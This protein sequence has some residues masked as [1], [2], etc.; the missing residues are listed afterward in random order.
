MAVKGRFK[1][2]DRHYLEGTQFD[3]ALITVSE[4]VD[5]K[6]GEAK[7]SER[8]HYFPKLTQV[9]SYLVAEEARVA[10]TAKELVDAISR[11]TQEITERLMGVEERLSREGNTAKIESVTEGEGNGNDEKESTAE[12]PAARRR[13][14][15]KKTASQAAK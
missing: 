7:I 15:K 8:K 11:S 6:T 12:K 3:W 2:T 1:L 4:V 5:K 14:R 13:T 10:G 9:A